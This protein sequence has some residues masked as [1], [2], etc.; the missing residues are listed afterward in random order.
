VSGNAETHMVCVRCSKP[1]SHGGSKALDKTPQWFD[2]D[3]DFMC[4]DGE[5]EHMPSEF[6]G[7]NHAQ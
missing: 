4:P 2:D 1:I 5:E 6:D 3:D 7:E